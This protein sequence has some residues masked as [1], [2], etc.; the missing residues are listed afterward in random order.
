MPEFKQFFTEEV[1]RLARKEIRQATARLQENI[2][3]LRKVAA[4][5]KK[6]IAALE[7]ALTRNADSGLPAIKENQEQAAEPRRIRI[8]AAGITKLRIRLGL[9]KKQFARLLNVSVHSV[10][11]WEQDKATPRAAVKARLAELRRLG[12]REIT[13]RLTELNETAGEPEA[14]P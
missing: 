6:R 2:S 11:L 13:A 1:R 10:I 9:N 7:N 12:K 14:Q 8:N 5:Q 4:E 3:N